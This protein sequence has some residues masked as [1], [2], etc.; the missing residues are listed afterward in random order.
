MTLPRPTLVPTYIINHADHVL[1]AGP[2]GVVQ[3]G[4]SAG[5]YAA[6]T[7]LLSSYRVTVDGRLPEP[8]QDAPLRFY[9]IRHVLR[10][11]QTGLVL[12]LDRSVRGGVHE[13]YV[14]QATGRAPVQAELAIEVGGDFADLFEVRGIGLEAPQRTVASRW[15]P[16]SGELR[17]GHRNGTFARGL[18]IRC[19][20]WPA[21]WRW[22]DGRLVLPVALSPR[23][24]IH[25]CLTWLPAGDDGSVSEAPGC[26]AGVRL[27]PERDGAPL[28]A[29]RLE[30]SNAPLG[31]AWTA[32]SWDMEA[33]R[34]PI[35]D[36]T[37]SDGPGSVPAAG[38]PWYLTL[39][40]RDSIITSLQA[41]PFYPELARGTLERLAALQATEDDPL[42]D[43]EPG[44]IL[45]E[46][47]SGEVARL[48]LLPFHPYYGTHDATPLYVTLLSEL[49]DWT[50]D[51]RLVE[52]FL[53]AAEAAMGWIE[54]FGDRDGDGFLEYQARSPHGFPN[55]GWK[56]AADAIPHAD[57]SLAP[58]PLA[59]CEHQAYAYEARLR[60]AEL[61]DALARDADAARLRAD[62]ARLRDRF[63]DV[64][65]WEEEGTY[66]LGLD[67]GKRPIRSVASNAGHCLASGIVPPDRAARVAARLLADDMWSGWGIRTLSAE[68][69]AYDPFSYHTGSVWPHDN[70]TIAAGFAVAGLRDQVA[71]VARATFE[72]AAE[73]PGLRLPEL[74]SGLPR[75]DGGPPVPYPGA[76]VPQAWA[77]SA[78]F[79][80][81]ILLCGIAARADRAGGA[82]V[83][84]DPALPE[85]LGDVTLRG[86]RAAGATLDLHV[87]GT[88]ST[89]LDNGSGLVVEHGSPPSRFP[90]GSG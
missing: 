42:R 44:K 26:H 58:A 63:N 68:H 75:S 38:L 49:Y 87:A 89:V 22:D 32:A 4:G 53:P 43:A 33:L 83:Y 67:G 37:G 40:G 13:D 55:Q 51:L 25:V 52:R 71:R 23:S 20:P 7:R 66:Y 24:A 78:L 36:A 85:W 84:L 14:L 8:I 79:R 19:R 10:D 62:A 45:H 35:P 39:F 30:T 46:V 15:D 86:V 59:L 76:N 29:P 80:L 17:L 90:D 21:P 88:A 28:R 82:R 81:V 9:S 2:G 34:L 6:D 16:T 1:I 5:F 47:R 74:F 61:Y 48:G 3:P 72:A 54:R 56:D 31:R 73:L 77:A 27:E 57:G 18:A 65:W 11:A 64:F 50:G 70:A 41:M 60:L 69:P 12:V